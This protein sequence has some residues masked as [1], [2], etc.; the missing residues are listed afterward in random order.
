M[1]LLHEE[2]D[3]EKLYLSK[4]FSVPPPTFIGPEQHGGM[5]KDLKWLLIYAPA[6]VWLPNVAYAKE[7]K[8][9]GVW[10]CSWRYSEKEYRSSLNIVVEIQ[11]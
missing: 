2:V 11:I 5:W 3:S 8:D 10:H 7:R 4:S 9:I 6:W 1:F